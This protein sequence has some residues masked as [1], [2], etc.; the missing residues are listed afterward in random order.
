MP[1]TVVTGCAVWS[2]CKRL[3]VSVREML[4]AYSVLTVIAEWAEHIQC[5]ALV[6]KRCM[7]RPSSMLTELTPLIRPEK[8][9]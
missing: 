8:G 7:T 1:M 2:E 6:R 9:Y 4:S 5:I 3:S